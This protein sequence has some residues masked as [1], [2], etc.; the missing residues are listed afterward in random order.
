MSVSNWIEFVNFAI[1]NRVRVPLAAIVI[2]CVL[3]IIATAAFVILELRKA[4]K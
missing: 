1:V 2:V 4:K 3:I